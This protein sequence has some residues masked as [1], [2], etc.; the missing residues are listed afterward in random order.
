MNP[1]ASSSQ[2]PRTSRPQ[3]GLRQ[4]CYSHVCALPWTGY[5]HVIAVP[6]LLFEATALTLPL[7][8][9]LTLSLTITP[10]CSLSAI[11]T[12]L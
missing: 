7:P 12:A 6:A 10:T 2:E 11:E 4:V 3:A 5:A 1:K 8:L 9:P